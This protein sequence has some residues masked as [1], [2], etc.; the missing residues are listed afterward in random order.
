MEAAQTVEHPTFET[1][2]AGLQEVRQILKENA[3]QQKET[4]RLMKE[5]REDFDRRM[6]QWTNFFGE[7]SEYMVAP[8]LRE[9][10]WE[11]GLDF[12]KANPNSS[13]NDRENGIFLKLYHYPSKR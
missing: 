13:V 5:S 7:I 9:K 8:K 6:G 1:V 3:E 4:D 10:F 12:P 2:W 11:F